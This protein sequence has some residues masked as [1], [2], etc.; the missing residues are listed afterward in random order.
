LT[1]DV[2]GPDNTRYLAHRA[3]GGIDGGSPP[4]M[5]TAWGMLTASANAAAAQ[6]A[7][8]TEDHDDEDE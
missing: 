7:E 6:L 1:I 5:W 2:A 8:A 4:V 3:G